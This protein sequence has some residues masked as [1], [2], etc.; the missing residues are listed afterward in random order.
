MAMV[1][2]RE[3]LIVKKTILLSLLAAGLLLT[4]IA[5]CGTVVRLDNPAATQAAL[6]ETVIAIQSTVLALE[7]EPQTALNQAVVQPSPQIVVVTAT[8]PNAPSPQPSATSRPTDPPPPTFTPT[9]LPSPTA[10]ATATTEVEPVIIVVTATPDPT[11]VVSR[12]DQSPSIVEPREGAVVEQGREV[13]L[14]WSWNGVLG[15]N[16][17]FDVKIRPDGQT[18][19]VY[20]AWAVGEAHNLKADLAPGRYFWSVQ[21]LSGRYHND[22]GQ[23]EDRIFEAFLSPESESR[24]IIVGEKPRDNPRSVSQADPPAPTLPYGILLG[25]LAFVTFAGFR[26]RFG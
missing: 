14:R 13:L 9:P 15:P 10:S 4:I 19:S 17:H 2:G 6:Q 20:V 24:L 3:T 25:G 16:E 23:P 1:F 8:P 11:P 26:T 5:A 7:N 18:R 22:S 12:Y 21:V